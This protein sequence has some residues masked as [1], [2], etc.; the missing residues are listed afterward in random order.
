MKKII[1]GLYGPTLDRGID[2]DRWNFWRPSVSLCQ[3]EDL[4]VDRYE[5]LIEKKFE[6][7]SQTVID[8]INTISPETTITPHYIQ[9]KDPWDFQEVY[10]TLHDF[11]RN[12]NFDT[13]NEEYYIHI[14]TGTHAVQICMF[15]L[16]ESLYFP[17]KLIQSSPPKRERY[18]DLGSYQVIDLDLSKYDGIAMRFKQQ[19]K[20]DISLLKSGIQTR[21]NKFNKLIERIEHVAS[22]TTDPILL[23]GPTGAGKSQLAK[24]I[25]QLKKTHRKL[26][27]SFV[28]VNCAT[29]RGDSA[30][31]VLFGHTKGAFTGAVQCRDGLLKT[32]DLGI[33]FLDEIGELGIE[34]QAMLLRAIEEKRFLPVGADKEVS[35]DFQL[36]CGTNRNLQ[37]NVNSGTF[38]EDLL[39][40][41]NLWTFTLPG[42]KDRPED[43]EPN[44]QYELDRY[45]RSTG[46]HIRFNKEALNRFLSF[47]TSYQA[48]WRSNF[49]DLIGAVTRMA[50]LAPGGRVSVDNVEEEIQ[51]L[52][53]SWQPTTNNDCP[54]IISE[55]LNQSQIQQIDDFD[56]P[57]LEHVLNI[58][59]ESKN[60]SEAGR[61]LFN[62]SRTQK[63][64]TNDADRLRKY[65]AKFNINWHDIHSS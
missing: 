65:L 8:D 4:L 44:I 21:N 40:R 25:F 60:L 43:I 26:K 47:S 39:A 31:S 33:L 32:A 36:I 18:G 20:D 12:Y 10:N 50:T 41:I 62:F 16:T 48:Q 57:Q 52:Q 64:R 23:T 27:G 53:N 42:L 59:S 35:S 17:G 37:A 15:L 22:R 56:K 6:N 5:L 14:T 54:S 46:T 11:A 7:I 61:K 13:D 29:I 3:H 55:I 45:E 2:A 63:I 1:I 9:W 19:I 49:R 24:Q 28:E 58:C 38:R 30:M 51:R 34:E